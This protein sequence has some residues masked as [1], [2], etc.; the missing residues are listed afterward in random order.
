MKAIET[1]FDGY[2]FRSRLEARWATFFKAL[3]I[4][5]RYEVEGFDL[6]EIRYL[7]DF[8]LPTLDCWIEI[9]GKEPTEDEKQKAE[10]LA[11]HTNKPVHIFWQDIQVPERENSRHRHYKYNL[12]LYEKCRAVFYG[13][14]IPFPFQDN[15]PL[16]KRSDEEKKIIDEWNAKVELNTLRV[17]DVP[18]SIAKVLKPYAHH[19]GIMLEE[20]E[21]ECSAYGWKRTVKMEVDPGCEDDFK[22]VQ[23]WEAV[24]S[25]LERNEELLNFLAVRPGWKCFFYDGCYFT[26]GWCECPT[27]GKLEI[28]GTGACWCTG[29]PPYPQVQF[30]SPR[31]IAAYT[32]ARQARF[33]FGR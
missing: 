12:P 4:E 23:D 22:D 3:G 19:V 10:L 33:E 15:L 13:P 6:G 9:K 21:Q 25:E 5:Y 11:Y 29:E 30:D 14:H 27:C 2:R 16:S 32:A 24:A 18:L 7:P 28:R 1:I 8:W 31:L 26:V 17:S 20:S